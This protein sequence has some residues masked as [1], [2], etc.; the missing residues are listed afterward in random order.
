M[1]PR[2]GSI[3][4]HNHVA[5]PWCLGAAGLLVG[6]LATAPCC[7]LG[8]LALA[9]SI[10]SAI[11]SEEVRAGSGRF[12]FAAVGISFGIWA[13]LTALLLLVAS[14]FDPLAPASSFVLMFVVPWGVFSGFEVL[15]LLPGGR[16][17]V[18]P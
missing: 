12:A 17:T 3:V 1:S 16:F 14:P 4:G 10:V 18:R 6:G 5:L 8:A 13:P 7:G 11:A 9:T 15:G 2:G